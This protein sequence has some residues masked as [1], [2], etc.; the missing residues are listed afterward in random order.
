M[1]SV[2]IDII[3]FSICAIWTLFIFPVFLQR[4]NLA[5]FMYSVL[6]FLLACYAS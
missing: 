2:I 1:L 6:L 5:F 3:E 4:K